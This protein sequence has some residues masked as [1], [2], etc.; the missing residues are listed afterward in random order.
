MLPNSV[1][2][3]DA[4][5]RVVA[6]I[7]VGSGPVAVA[8]SQNAVWIAN[9]D[10]G[11]VS[12]MDSKERKIVATIGIGGEVSDLAV[13][14]GTIWVAGGNDETLT[15]IDPRINA[16]EA[17]LIFG[18][19]DPLHPRPIFAVATGAGAVWVTRGNHV[20][21][22]DPDT[23]EVTLDISIDQPR[24]L[25]VGAGA[26]WITTASERMVRIEPSTGAVTG[27]ISLPAQA[28]APVASR[29]TLWA[30]VGIGGGEIW[31][32]D[33]DT[34]SPTGTIRIGQVP[35]DL[36]LAGGTLWVATIVDRS[37]SRID[38]VTGR[39][40]ASVRVDQRPT[41]IASGEG[42]VW[43]AVET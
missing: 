29:R 6:D 7:S 3:I 13:G 37:V 12:R 4:K 28:Y 14:Y 20:L 34:G 30:V 32:F 24:S 38:G 40:E 11:T 19:A 41:A 36:A 21:R 2:V 39:I 35:V 42:A 1:A 27:R 10:D 31:R 9:G 23:N 17:R 33:A 25:V 18:R 8:T 5:P 15:R 16:V 43:V 22:I 26:L